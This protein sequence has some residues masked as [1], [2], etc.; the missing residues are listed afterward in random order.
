VQNFVS[1]I[2]FSQN[3]FKGRKTGGQFNLILLGL[4]HDPFATGGGA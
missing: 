1:H 3:M 4:F 2:D